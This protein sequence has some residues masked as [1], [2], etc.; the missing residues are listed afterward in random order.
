MP[1]RSIENY[2]YRIPNLLSDAECKQAVKEFKTIKFEDHKFYHPLKKIYYKG[3]GSQELS[4]SWDDI[5]CRKLIMDR[6][7]T[8]IQ[9]YIDYYNM[10]WFSSWQGYSAVKFNEY[11]ENK[12]MALHCESNA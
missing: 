9:S 1:K 8:G 12:K 4:M 7:Y 11:K 6:I 5:P 2:I 10:P 3:S